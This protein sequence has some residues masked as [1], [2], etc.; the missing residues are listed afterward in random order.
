ML[1]ETKLCYFLVKHQNKQKKDSYKYFCKYCYG[2][3]MYK[4]SERE[5]K[6][7]A[8]I[9]ASRNVHF[10]NKRLDFW[11]AMSVSLNIYTKSFMPE[12]A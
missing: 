10:S 1:Q 2:K 8:W 7:S 11:K 3:N 4:L 6:N 12:P 5:R 9:G